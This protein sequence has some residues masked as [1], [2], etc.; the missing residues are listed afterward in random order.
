MAN[1]GDDTVSVIATASGRVT[2]TTVGDGPTGIAITPDGHHAYVTNALDGTVSVIA[3][4]TG[5]V[6]PPISVGTRPTGIR[7]T[8]DGLHAYVADFGDDTVS[9]VAT[10]TAVVSAPIGVGRYPDGVEITPGR[11]SRLRDELRR[12]NSLGDQDVDAEGRDH[13]HRR[14]PSTRGCDLFDWA[15]APIGVNAPDCRPLACMA[16]FTERVSM[17]PSRELRAVSLGPTT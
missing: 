17:P 4:A 5:R 14:R 8:P 9:V 12:Y 6:A 16:S 10:A 13:H 3:T 7:I 1:F 11:P 15:Q 2:T